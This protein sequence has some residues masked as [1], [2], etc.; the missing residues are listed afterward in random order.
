MST[1][2]LHEVACARRLVCDGAMGTQLMLAGLEQ[3]ACGGVWNP[4]LPPFIQNVR[5]DGR[6][7][8]IPPASLLAPFD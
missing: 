7:G 8:R 1:E 3:G 6:A 2:P 5:L 4:E